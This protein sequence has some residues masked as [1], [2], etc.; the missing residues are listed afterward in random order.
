M[1]VG[2]QGLVEICYEILVGGIRHR[3]YTEQG[4][5]VRGSELSHPAGF[6]LH[7]GSPGRPQAPLFGGG[8]RHVIDG[9]QQAGGMGNRGMRQ[10]HSEPAARGIH[11]RS[12]KNIADFQR[13]IQRPTE[14]HT[15]NR[16]RPAR[17]AGRLNGAAGVRGA[18]AIRHHPQ[19]AAGAFALPCP[20]DGTRQLAYAGTKPQQ[21]V[22]LA[23]FSGH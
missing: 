15:D 2:K 13:R 4:D 16:L 11:C 20:K 10:A 7:S 17:L 14:S 3:P 9:G 1:A 5:I 21:P 8:L 6:H 22:E 12:H 18:R 23:G 19:F